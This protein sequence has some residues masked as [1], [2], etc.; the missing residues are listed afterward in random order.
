MRIRPIA[1]AFS[2]AVAI[3]VLAAS[4]VPAAAQQHRAECRK[5]SRQIA[6]Y[7]RDAGWA[8][9]RGN[10]LWLQ[11]DLNQV[12]KLTVHREALCPTPKGPSNMEVVADL[13]GKAAKIAAKY[14]IK[15]YYPF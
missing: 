14:F 2:I 6:R 13:V 8:K 9:D 7:E 1:I 15:Q 3:A 11:S 10:A 12:E 5:L 4:S